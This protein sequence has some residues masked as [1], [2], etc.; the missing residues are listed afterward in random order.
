MASHASVPT[1]EL[2]KGDLYRIYF[3]PRDRQNRSHI[4]YLVIDIKEP[5]RVIEIAEEPNLAPGA[6]G[7]FDDSGAMFSWIVHHEGQRWLY[8]IGWSLG[9]D[10][11]WRT[12][13]GLAHANA[14][15]DHPHFV[16]YS[17]GPIIDRSTADPFF[18]TNPFVLRE[19]E[20]WRMWYLSG[21]GWQES[22]NIKLPRYNVRYAESRDGIRWQVTG[23]VCVSHA[24]PGEVAIGRPFV[25][26]EDGIYK[27]FYSYRGDSFGY[28]MGYAESLDGL[29]WTRQDAQAGLDGPGEEWDSQ[30][31]AYPTIFDHNGQRY[32]LYCGNNFSKGGFGIAALSK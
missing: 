5:T 10:T 28:R 31:K 18:V 3:S 14:E 8:Y 1:P 23:H 25:L 16:R 13:I 27:M 4:G 19:G 7:A 21:L 24:Y 9:V 12:A 29:N 11:P 30:G 32:M 22:N 17:A 6:L 26:H 15:D 20:R 2:I